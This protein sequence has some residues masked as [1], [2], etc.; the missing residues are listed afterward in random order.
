[1]YFND[2]V[3]EDENRAPFPEC[4]LTGSAFRVVNGSSDIETKA[5]Y[6]TQ[7]AGEGFPQSVASGDPT[8]SG[9]MIWTRV[10][11]SLEAGA[12]DIEIGGGGFEWPNKPHDKNNSSFADLI[13]QGKTV[14]FQVSTHPNF[15]FV[16]LSGFSPVWKDH[17]HVVRMDLDGLLHPN[18][19]YYYRFITRS[20][21]V[22][23]AGRCRTL[24]PEGSDCPAATIGYVSC[25]DYTSGYFN[26]L[27]HL[28]DEQ[29]DFF[30]HLG[31]YIYEA[32]GEA[33]YQTGLEA[34]QITLPSGEDKAFTLEDYRHLYNVYRTDPDLQKLH[35]NHAMVAT[36]DDHEF[37]NDAYA[38]AV[39]PDDSLEPDLKR[40]HSA[41]SAWLEYMPSRVYVPSRS[42]SSNALKLYRSMTIGD[43]AT[44]YITDE[45]AYRDAHP[46][47]EQEL[48]RYFTDGCENIHSPDRS[49]L[50]RE[51]KDW[52]LG[53]LK[54]S[55]S[56]WN[57][58]ANQ[59][60]ITQL[61]FL[62]RYINLDAWDGF[63]HERQAIAQ[64]VMN[65]GIQ[66]FI[67][68]TGDFHSFE[69]SYLQ[70]DY[71]RDGHKFGVELMVGSVTS[72]NLNEMV[73]KNLNNLFDHTSPLPQN[74]TLEIFRTFLPDALSKRII[75]TEFLFKELQNAIKIENPWI[76]LFDSTSHGY[77]L[78][79]LSKSRA[80]WTA[81]AVESIEEKQA[82]KSLLLQCEI[83]NGEAAIN[84]K[85]KNSLFG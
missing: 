9:M 8:S 77:A 40:R 66:N 55:S 17:D 30:L 18:E 83:P 37:A 35:E 65:K 5:Y 49:M 53:E 46:C 2:S 73:Q 38:P 16:E 68:L 59:V 85:E 11:P 78:L 21:L 22:S 1:M 69:A 81:Y 23:K 57:I 62:G 44:L 58:W 43:L 20:G 45:R 27:A 70:E 80:V 25:Q 72:S 64:T 32:A 31:D 34:R 71:S 74:A 6:A 82:S 47:G 7:P 13:D 15:S 14:M 48:E 10:D 51:Q 3:R 79:E 33:S 24:P 75:P 41:N 60:Q 52:F 12:S 26:A 19:T 29:M 39:A 4:F 42:S 50:G 28:A 84:V 54:N 36:W 63:A 76:E 56:L 61:K 67:V